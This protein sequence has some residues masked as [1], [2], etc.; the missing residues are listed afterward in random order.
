ML[1][2]VVEDDSSS[3][4]PRIAKVRNFNVKTLLPD[5]NIMDEAD[6]SNPSQNAT[7]ANNI[8]SYQPRYQ[9]TTEFGHGGSN[10]TAVFFINMEKA[11]RAYPIAIIQFAEFSP[12]RRMVF[13]A[14]SQSL[15]LLI[16]EITSVSSAL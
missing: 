2:F 6:I 5:H 11:L 13:E 10:T 15:K 16:L 12:M 8:I 7:G 4:R 3:S 9:D 1:L 14:S